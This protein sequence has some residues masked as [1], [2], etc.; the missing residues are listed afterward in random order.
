VIRINSQSGKGGVTY[1][2]ERDLGL[3]LPRWLQIDFSRRVQAEAEASNSE[4]SPEQIRTLFEQHYLEPPTAIASVASSSVA[5][6]RRAC[7][8]SCRPPRLPA[9]VR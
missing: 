8:S 1:L 7:A 5:T 4:I 6:V 2:L 9:I 3:Q